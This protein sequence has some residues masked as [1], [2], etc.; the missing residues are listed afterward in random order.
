MMISNVWHDI[1]GDGELESN[2]LAKIIY[3]YEAPDRFYHSLSHIEQCLEYIDAKL[4]PS[5]L[6]AEYKHLVMAIIYHDVVYFMGTP[7]GTSAEFESSQ[8]AR[9]DLKQLG[10]S[11]YD[12]IRVEALIM[13]TEYSKTMHDPFAN[14]IP[15]LKDGNFE[16]AILFMR[17]LDFH[18]IGNDDTK[19]MLIN[20][21]GVVNEAL[22]C[23]K[24]E[25]DIWVGRLGFLKSLIGK[26]IFHTAQFKAE[27]GN[28]AN[29]NIM[30]EYALLKEFGLEVYKNL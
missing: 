21:M 28:N 23:G 27:F 17:D 16:S 9:N 15:D 19:A 4:S 5:V 10:W 26:E 6:G 11:N 29:I 14:L 12:I 25:D 18:G 13:A 7:N 8:R 30:T 2:I 22:A 1:V 3:A 20:G 24:A